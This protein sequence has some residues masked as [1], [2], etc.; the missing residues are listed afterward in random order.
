MKMTLIAILAA[1]LLLLFG[2]AWLFALLVIMNGVS[3]ARATPILISYLVLLLL[4]VVG[5]GWAGGWGSR[6][7]VTTWNWNKWVS[8][9]LTLLA[10]GVS[11]I[12]ILVIGSM[13]LMLAFGVR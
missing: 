1:I 6:M 11:G 2:L 12:V 13:V 4:T 10:L 8:G 3:E 9:L 7:L 5:G